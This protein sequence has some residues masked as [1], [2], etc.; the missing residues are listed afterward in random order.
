ML[1]YCEEMMSVKKGDV[2]DGVVA[3]LQTEMVET[4]LERT[5][6]IRGRRGREDGGDHLHNDSVN[7]NDESRRIQTE[8]EDMENEC[9][10]FGNSR[11]ADQTE[12]LH[13]DL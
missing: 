11:I 13:S 5:S 10:E 8:I 4:H 12:L 7:G 6:C 3:R 2:R 9:L 1:K